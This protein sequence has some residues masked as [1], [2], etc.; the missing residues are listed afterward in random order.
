MDIKLYLKEKRTLIDSF[1]KNHFKIKFKPSVLRESMLYSLFAGG[2]RLRPIL[3]LA[4]YEACGKNPIEIVKYASA[5]ELI[6]TYSLIHDDL[7]SMDNDDL[8]RGKPTNHIVFG[9]AMAILAGD[10]LLTE[11]FRMLSE[12]AGK[13]KEKALLKGLNEVASAAGI[14]GMVAGQAMDIISEDKRPDKKTLSFIH[15]NKTAALIAASARLGAILSDAGEKKFLSLSRYGQCIGLAFQIVDDILDIKGDTGELGKK[16]GSDIRK[17][18]MT[19]PSLYG[20]ERSEAKAKELI[21]E[22]IKSLKPLSLKAE[23][24][25]E[26][27]RYITERRN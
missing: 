10:A 3:A 27:A 6:H 12:P 23:P 1:L 7:P 8:R 13:I 11:A 19:Y 5:L 22:A 26:I 9:E 4:S 25:R 14:Y 17:K 16:T 18:K 20:I 24:M 2:K 15:K 21:K